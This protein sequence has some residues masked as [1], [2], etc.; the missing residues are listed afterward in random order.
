MPKSNVP[1]PFS[2]RK[3]QGILAQPIDKP[4][5]V[6]FALMSAFEGKDVPKILELNKLCNLYVEEQTNERLYALATNYGILGLLGVKHFGWEKELLVKLA[7]DFV[8]GFTS[9][10]E[11]IKSNKG[12]KKKS[13]E[14]EL[15]IQVFEIIKKSNTTAANACRLISINKKNP[16]HGQRPKSLLER[17]NRMKAAMK[18]QMTEGATQS[19]FER[20]IRNQEM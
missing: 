11:N 4:N 16:W 8:V 19:P 2:G 17:F 6:V 7:S 14:H 15:A 1:R 20:W 5:A 12:R 9:I 13:P 18:R 3:F 10:Q